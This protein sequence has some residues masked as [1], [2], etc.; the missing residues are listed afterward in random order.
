MS[1]R[2]ASKTVYAIAA[3][4]T[5]NPVSVNFATDKSFRKIVGVALKKY[6][7]PTNT[8]IRLS[9][10]SGSLLEFMPTDLIEV[11][12]SSANGKERFFPVDIDAAGAN[13][14]VYVQEINPTSGT[15]PNTLSAALN[16]AV[17]FLY[18]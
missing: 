3:N 7:G 4:A 11:S 16:V 14:N 15:V 10:D 8:Q 1:K 9:N 13:V 17:T 2:V 5:A 12:A 18:E 6:A